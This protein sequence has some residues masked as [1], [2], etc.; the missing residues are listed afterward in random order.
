MEKKREGK[1]KGRYLCL[2]KNSQNLSQIKGLKIES[3]M[4]D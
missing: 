3:L 1:K 4:V 2:L